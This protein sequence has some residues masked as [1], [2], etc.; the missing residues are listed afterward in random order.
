MPSGIWDG[1]LDLSINR[2]GIRFP[3]FTLTATGLPVVVKD[4]YGA[5]L[6]LTSRHGH[7]GTFACDHLN[8]HDQDGLLTIRVKGILRGCGD[9]YTVELL[10]V[11]SRH[12]KTGS[13]AQV[14]QVTQASRRTVKGR[15]RVGPAPFLLELFRPRAV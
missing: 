2:G 8:I 3:R 9:S 4:S 6:R 15:Q 5:M 7:E 13:L 10:H 1:V 11:E 14:V 12:D